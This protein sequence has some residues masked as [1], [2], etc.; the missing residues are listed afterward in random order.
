MPCCKVQLPGGDCALLAC[1]IDRAFHLDVDNHAVVEDVDANRWA[2]VIVQPVGAPG[3]LVEPVNVFDVVED[4]ARLHCLNMRQVLLHD[5]REA[6][7]V[8]LATLPHRDCR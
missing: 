4:A 8:L 6:L 7:D 5:A 1:R 3:N 2:A